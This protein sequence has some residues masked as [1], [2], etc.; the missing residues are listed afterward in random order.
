[1]KKNAKLLLLL[2][3]SLT[4]L[5]TSCDVKEEDD[6]CLKKEPLIEGFFVLS[7]K[8]QYKDGVP[9]GGDVNF[10]I[11]KTYCNGTMNGIYTREGNADEEGYYST[12]YIYSYKYENLHDKV[13]FYFEIAGPENRTWYKYYYVDIK[14]EDAY[15]VNE[16]FEITLDWDSPG[17]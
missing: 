9:Y 7:A 2:I 8:I 10:K 15:T 13:E 12:G 5:R 17:K 6:V 3:I 11:Y 1:M 16:A 14:A 4:F